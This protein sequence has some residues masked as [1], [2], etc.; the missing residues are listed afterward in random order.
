MTHSEEQETWWR[1]EEGWGASGN[2]NAS[3][4]VQECSSPLGS[5]M[6]EGGTGRRKSFC[7]ELSP[8]PAAKRVKPESDS[9]EGETGSGTGST[10][11]TQ[12]D[13]EEAAACSHRGSHS[14][15]VLSGISFAQEGHEWRGAAERKLRNAA[16]T[17]RSTAL[18]ARENAFMV[19]AGKT[20]GIEY[21]V[22]QRSQMPEANAGS[23]NGGLLVLP[24]D[25]HGKRLL[26]S[27]LVGVVPIPDHWPG[28][29]HLREWIE[30]KQVEKGLRPRGLQA[31]REAMILDGLKQHSSAMPLQ[32]NTAST[33]I[34][35]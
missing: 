10:T 1:N 4:A 5:P 28:E 32:I 19:R 7:L 25:Q 9:D 33:V 3:E 30:T 21:R 11:V 16:V 15:S 14:P 13:G 29:L 24:R 8:E 27:E 18:S 23:A 2:D 20:Q 35:A 17:G 26:P 12:V 34:S 22:Q 31:A 6:E